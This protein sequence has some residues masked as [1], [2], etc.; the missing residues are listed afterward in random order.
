MHL[1][2]FSTA[3]LL[4]VALAAPALAQTAGNTGPA[5]I[6]ATRDAPFQLPGEATPMPPLQVDSSSLSRGP[7]ALDR[8]GTAPVPA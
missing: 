7:A 5:E 1:R 4:S 6:P 3:I 2:S 8:A